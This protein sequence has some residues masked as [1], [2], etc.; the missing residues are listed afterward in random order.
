MIPSGGKFRMKIK[1][2]F[3][4][5]DGKELNYSVDFERDAVPNELIASTSE[6]WTRLEY[7]KC[8]NC[9]LGDDESY[10]PA[11]VD[12]QSI[13]T[14]FRSLP[15]YQKAKVDVITPERSFSKTTSL[16]EGVRSLMGLVFATSS[17]PVLSELRPM[18]ET[19][20]PFATAE[21]FIVKSVSTYLI[22]QYF[23]FQSGKKPDWEMDGLVER[24][25]RLQL[26]NQSLWQRIHTVCEGDSNLKVLLSFFSMSSS[27]SFSLEGQMSKLKE[28][29]VPLK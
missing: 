28:I 27:V 10:C 7:C 24:N 26:V 25:K 12:I 29:F 5:Q 3:S 21:E 18:A 4:F 14:G 1:Y 13:V 2:K 8:I 16:E 17:C 9:P 6:D 19:H 20:L 23:Y 11:A 15:A 22:Q